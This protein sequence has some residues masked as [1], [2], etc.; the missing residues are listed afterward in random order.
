MATIEVVGN[1]GKQSSEKAALHH[2]NPNPPSGQKGCVE[3]NGQ[4]V[5]VQS[6]FGLVLIRI[7][8][9]LCAAAQVL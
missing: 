2:L 3:T 1:T 6:H 4:A 5:Q 8:L 7:M 9:S